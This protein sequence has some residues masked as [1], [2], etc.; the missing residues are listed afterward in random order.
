MLLINDKPI[1]YFKFPGGE[2]QVK[3]P[4]FIECERVELTWL[5]TNSEDIMLLLLAANALKHYG[6][7]DIHL[8]CLYLPY[9]RQDRVCN[10]G[11]AF[12][13]ELICKLLDGC[14]FAGINFWDLHNWSDTI[15]LFKNTFV[16]EAEAS[17]IFARF[18]VLDNFDL[19]NLMLCAPDGGA[20]GRVDAICSK[21]DVWHPSIQLSKVRNCE[22]GEIT[23]LQYSAI[24]S[25]NPELNGE[26]VL[27]VDDICD[28]GRTF[29]EAAKLLKTKTAGKLYL[30][31]THG[32]FSRGLTELL[33]HYE[34]IYCH[35]VLDH[36]FKSNARLTI[37]KEFPNE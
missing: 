22:T 20:W 9:A 35:H 23:G 11:E 14:G 12:S 36:D 10:P 32:I 30:Y 13:L 29:I 24:T 34:H 16:F 2:L 37:L 21:F 5:P 25:F 3:L 1:N 18:K 26:T 4:D 27:V 28:G 17:D 33:R 7:Y 8:D 15:P 31:V 19:K 6:I